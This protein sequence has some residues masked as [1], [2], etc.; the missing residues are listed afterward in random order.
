MSHRYDLKTAKRWDERHPDCPSKPDGTAY[1]RIPKAKMPESVSLCDGVT[2]ILG[3]LTPF[4]IVPWAGKL[5][6]KAGM[7][8]PGDEGLAKARYN[9]LRTEAADVGSELHAVAEGFLSRG[10]IPDGKEKVIHTLANALKE[11]LPDLSNIQTEKQ[12]AVERE[13]GLRYGGTSDVL[14]SEPKLVADWKFIKDN[15]SPYLSECA[16]VVAYG[17]AEFGVGS[18]FRCANIL[19]NQKTH[20]LVCVREWHPGE[21]ALGRQYFTHCY[22]LKALN[23]GWDG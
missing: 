13:D 23:D 12:F 17:D 11:L 4:H 3:I 19:V 2:S 16:Q 22:H 1:K 21:I 20:D 5:G 6:I 9:E 15:R 14:C 10:V 18:D 8:Y 7:Q